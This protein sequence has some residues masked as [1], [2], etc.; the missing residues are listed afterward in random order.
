MPDENPSAPRLLTGQPRVT[1]H[2]FRVSEVVK[3]H[4][5]RRDG[6]SLC[7]VVGGIIADEAGGDDELWAKE[8]FAAIPG[9][10]PDA[11]RVNRKDRELE[12]W[13]VVD[14][15]ARNIPKYFGL[16]WLLD[17]CGW[18]LRLHYVDAKTGIESEIDLLATDVD[19]TN[20]KILPGMLVVK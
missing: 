9:L 16:F 15:C 18:T 11:F 7:F 14:T 20:G 3:R 2:S 6:H 12:C 8:S 1:L 17:D 13:E 10:V 19:L 4:R 5:L